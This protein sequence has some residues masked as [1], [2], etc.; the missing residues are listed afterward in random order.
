MSTDATEPLVIGIDAGG[1]RLRI[2][3][4]PRHG[5]EMRRLDLPSENAFTS[6]AEAFVHRVLAATRELLLP[7]E[8]SR[9]AVVVIG[10]AGMAPDLRVRVR[11]DVRACLA[12]ESAAVRVHVLSDAEVAFA[13]TGMSDSG[14]VIIAGT[15]AIASRIDA[16][17][18]VATVDGNGAQLGDLGSGYWIGMSGAQRALR[19][20]EGV[21][22]PT[23]LTERL[24]RRLG[25]PEPRDQFRWAMITA[26]RSLTT[27]EIAKFAEDVVRLAE[28][29]DDVAVAI[30]D[31][32]VNHL[33][34]S[35]QAARASGD[36]VLV[37]AG[38]LLSNDTAVSRGLRARVGSD[39]PTVV[40]A[41][42]PVL[43][44]LRT[45]QRL[46]REPWTA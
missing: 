34:D 21:G 43:G 17:R 33:A 23:Q 27:S 44:S 42:N 6:G 22:K 10:A 30:V 28:E 18:E 13:S 8:L 11:D 9:L 24:R 14:V 15:G 26:Y 5:G 37:L 41:D 35:I 29:G 16:G 19:A 25:L 7:S 1:S 36:G 12:I 38:S 40:V 2:S 4:P 31:D 32:A 3:A 46:A 45:A 20:A 39:F